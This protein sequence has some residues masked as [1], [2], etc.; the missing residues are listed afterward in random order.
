MIS[1]KNTEAL[2]IM[3]EAG[4][5]LAQVVSRSSLHIKPGISTKELDEIV[6]CEMRVEKL[7]PVCKGVPGYRHATCI[8][9]NNGVVHGVPSEKVVLKNGDLVKLDV[10]GGF[11]GYCVDMARSFFVGKPQEAAQHLVLVAQSALD[12]A[13]SLAVPGRHLSDLSHC[14][15]QEVERH[16]YGVVRC[17]AGHG[18]GKKLHEDPEIPNYGAPGKG[19]ILKP[20]MVLAIEPMITLGHYDVRVLADGWTAVTVDGSLAAHVEDTVAI[21]EHG[22][23]ILTRGV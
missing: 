11:K 10:V 7:L 21:T 19:P 2:A 6:E 13:I 1:I 5:K 16:G 20:G 4:A 14:I 8:S 18:I 23:K 22:P 17:F 9:I 3:A 12:K 15:Q